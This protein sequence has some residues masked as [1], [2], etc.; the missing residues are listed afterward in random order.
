MARYVAVINGPAGETYPH[1]FR[2]ESD[3]RSYLAT[4]KENGWDGTLVV[5]EVTE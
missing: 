1:P 2:T 4:C 5:E 3:A